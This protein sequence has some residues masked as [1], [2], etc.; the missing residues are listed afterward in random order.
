MCLCLC[1]CAVISFVRLCCILGLCVR[2]RVYV[3]AC[4]QGRGGAMAHRS[5]DEEG[6]SA[7]HHRVRVPRD[8]VLER[9]G[10]ADSVTRSRW[11]RG[12]CCVGRSGTRRHGGSC[13]GSALPWAWPYCYSGGGVGIWFVIKPVNVATG[14]ARVARLTCHW[15]C[16]KMDSGTGFSFQHSGRRGIREWAKA[17]ST[18]T[19]AENIRHPDPEIADGICVYVSV[20]CVCV[21]RERRATG[22][23]M[24][25]LQSQ[26]FVS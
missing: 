3:W 26:S 18:S 11:R 16:G 25:T 1:L 9:R 24:Y 2:V 23:Y 8:M 5:N 13:S 17:Y 22:V 19:K 7:P 12:V 4:H 20:T 15:T 21:S 10:A 14:L 6:Q